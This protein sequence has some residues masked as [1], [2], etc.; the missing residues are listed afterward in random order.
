MRWIYWSANSHKQ[1]ANKYYYYQE[2]DRVRVKGKQT[3]VIIYEPLGLISDM[4]EE[5]ILPTQ[6]FESTLNNYC[7]QNW[8]YCFL[9]DQK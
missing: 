1:A 9:F 6:S 2:I 4:S 3:P 7:T 8:D 5:K